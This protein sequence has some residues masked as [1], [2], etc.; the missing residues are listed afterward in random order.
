M[1]FPLNRIKASN[2]PKT[3]DARFD[4]ANAIFKGQAIEVGQFRSRVDKLTKLLKDL[5]RAYAKFSADLGAWV[6]DGAHGSVVESSGQLGSFAQTL[7]AHL[8]EQFWPRVDPNFLDPLV[9]WEREVA[10]VAKLRGARMDA[11]QA[12]DRDRELQ[13][14]AEGAKKPKQADIDKARART[15]ESHGKYERTNADFIDAVNRLSDK[16]GASVGDPFRHMFAISCQFIDAVAGCARADIASTAVVVA[17]EPAAAEA[18][19]APQAASAQPPA[20]EP[21][22]QAARCLCRA[23]MSCSQAFETD[24]ER[25]SGAGSRRLGL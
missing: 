13:R 2:A 22:S 9:A 17:P 20:P 7:D 19:P 5:S 10:D 1:A 3:E 23:S 6:G 14:L 8:T 21:P 24:R 12:F 25:R 16:R 15:E 18:Q 4:E 11:C